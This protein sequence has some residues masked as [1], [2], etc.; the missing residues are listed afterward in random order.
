MD[1]DENESQRDIERGVDELL[2]EIGVNEAIARYDE[3]T[4]PYR[5]HIA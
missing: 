2:A 1:E 3:L 5:K 4:D